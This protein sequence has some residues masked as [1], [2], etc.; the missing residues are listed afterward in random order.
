MFAY[1]YVNPWTSPLDLR[2]GDRSRNPGC[3]DM[4]WDGRVSSPV[5]PDCDIPMTEFDDCA[6]LCCPTCGVT[7]LEAARR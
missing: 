6:R 4:E 7:F 1:R 2:P 3:L 5:C